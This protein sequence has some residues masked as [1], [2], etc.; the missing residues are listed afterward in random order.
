MVCC[1]L[2]RM[3]V[4]FKRRHLANPL[5]RLLSLGRSFKVRVHA[6]PTLLVIEHPNDDVTVLF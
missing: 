1:V 6:R 3:P 2:L 5:S 4:N